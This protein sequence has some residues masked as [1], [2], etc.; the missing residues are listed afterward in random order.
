MNLLLDTHSFL[1]F[2]DGDPQLS[3]TAR[4][5]IETKTNKSFLSIASLWEIA[6][7]LSIGK[8]ELTRSF[9]NALDDEL[10]R[11]NLSPLPIE[12]PHIAKVA[13]LPLH[14]RDPFDRLLIAQAL[15]QQLPIV[16]MD[17]AFDAYGVT[18]LW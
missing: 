9:E 15:V 17:A 10:A 18:R 4:A 13:V 2:I 3:A 5:L 1:W 12:L 14:H 7:K 6:I 8:L 11:R 16:S